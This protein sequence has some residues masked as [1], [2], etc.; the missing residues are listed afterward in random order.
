M[1]KGKGKENK[2]HRG[3]KGFSFDFSLKIY[4]SDE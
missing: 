1:A 2:G 3:N 4:S